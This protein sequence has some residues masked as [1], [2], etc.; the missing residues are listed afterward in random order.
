MTD[1]LI[2]RMARAYEAGVNGPSNW[3]DVPWYIQDA[4]KE[5][6]RAALAA[7]PFDPE[8]QVIMPREMTEE[9]TDVSVLPD[10]IQDRTYKAYIEAAC[11]EHQ[12]IL[13]SPTTASD[14]YRCVKC[15]ATV[16]AHTGEGPPPVNWRRSREGSINAA[17]E[18]GE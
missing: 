17:A 2:E 13:V 4:V 5:G 1:D 11:T 3:D 12:W 6:V 9:M 14:D 16:L 7:I 15:G 8:T 10:H 18:A